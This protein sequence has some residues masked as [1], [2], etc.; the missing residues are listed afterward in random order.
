MSAMGI[1]VHAVITPDTAINGALEGVDV[2]IV[3]CD[4]FKD[5]KRAG[6]LLKSIVQ[7][8]GIDVVHSFHNRAYKMGV[9]ARLMGAKFKLFINRGVISKPNSIFFLWTALSS[10][11][12]ANSGQCAEVMSKYW[13]RKK[14]LNVVYNAYAGPDHGEPQPRKKRGTRFIYIGNTVDIKGFDVFLDAAAKL[15]ESDCRDI[16]FV[17]VGVP[18]DRLEWFADNL[19]PAVRER[20]RI[21]GVIPHEQVLEELQFA[22]VLCVTSRK[23]SLPNALLEGFDLGLPGV[24]TRV[25]G[26]PEIIRDGVNGFICD[27]EDSTCLAEKMRFMVDNPTKRYEMGVNGRA[28]V[29]KLLTPEAKAY[30]LLRVYMGER[31]YEPLPIESVA[32]EVV[33]D[34]QAC[35]CKS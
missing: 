7:E 16:E 4:Y 13:V 22:D 5:Y 34:D 24:C 9:L 15:C 20:L 29:R 30:N 17:A 19:T 26:I 21:A 14:L 25:G 28:V 35:G 11:V 23:E 27:S 6:K 12:I 10:G 33:G 1:K 2:E 3:H 8:N 31:M 18:E 32:N